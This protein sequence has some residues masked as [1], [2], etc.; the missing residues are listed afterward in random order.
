MFPEV[1]KT[2]DELSSDTSWKWHTLRG[3]KKDDRD[4][5]LRDAAEAAKAE[6]SVGG[7]LAGLELIDGDD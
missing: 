1:A 2:I 4:T 6:Y 3:A 5:I 7:S